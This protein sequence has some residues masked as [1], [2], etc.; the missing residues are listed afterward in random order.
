MSLLRKQIMINERRQYCPHCDQDFDLL[1]T[2]LTLL[3][4]ENARLLKLLSEGVD[5]M[6]DGVCLV[7]SK[8]LDEWSEVRVWLDI[9]G[10][11]I[12][13]SGKQS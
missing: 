9:A 12:L 2:E 11:T 4:E 10:Q 1:T 5:A 3:R 13:R 7:P 8:R 6:N